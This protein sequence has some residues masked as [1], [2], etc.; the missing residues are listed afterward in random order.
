MSRWFDA[1]ISIPFPMIFLWLA[2]LYF[3]QIARF[4]VKYLAGGLDINVVDSIGGSWFEF[5]T[6]LFDCE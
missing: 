5:R 2:E 6:V 3:S 4:R 1:S